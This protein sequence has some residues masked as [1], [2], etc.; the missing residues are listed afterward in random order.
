M[1]VLFT[2]ESYAEYSV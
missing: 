2:S 1:F